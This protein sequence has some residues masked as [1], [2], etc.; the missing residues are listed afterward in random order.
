MTLPTTKENNDKAVDQSQSKKAHEL[1]AL[2]LSF[3][4]HF[5]SYVLGAA[6]FTLISFQANT[7]EYVMRAPLLW[8]GIGLLGHLLGLIIAELVA[9]FERRL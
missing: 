6:I 1:T 2:R 7:G 4:I 3:W 8:W 5:A 9:R